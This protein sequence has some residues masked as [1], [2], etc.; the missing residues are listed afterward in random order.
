MTRHIIPPFKN[1]ISRKC[2]GQF[3]GLNIGTAAAGGIGTVVTGV[4]I[5]TR[6]IRFKRAIFHPVVWVGVSNTVS[7]S[8]ESLTLIRSQRARAINR[9]AAAGRTGKFNKSGRAGDSKAGN[10]DTGVVAVA[11]AVA[12]GL[13][14]LF[15]FTDAGAQ[16]LNFIV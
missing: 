1:Q 12:V 5:G 10:A 16:E 14:G 6:R 2:L 9:A 8:A 4:G 11:G 7:L 13:V 15:K 3:R